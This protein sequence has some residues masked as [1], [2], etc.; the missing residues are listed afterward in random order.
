MHS[1]VSSHLTNFYIDEEG[2]QFPNVN[3]YYEKVGYN[4][5]YLKNL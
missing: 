4:E 2:N 3:L 1:S 5:E